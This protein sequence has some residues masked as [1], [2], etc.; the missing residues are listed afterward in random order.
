MRDNPLNGKG[1]GHELSATEIRPADFPLGSPKSRA[2]ARALLQARAHRTP[3]EQEHDK[4]DARCGEVNLREVA[5]CPNCFEADD[6]TGCLFW[7]Q[8]LTMTED[9]HWLAKGT[10]AK[11]PFP[12]KDYFRYVLGTMQRPLAYPS[13]Q[14]QSLYIPKTREMMTSWLA[15]GYIAWLCQW[16]PGIFFVLQ[17]EKEDKAVE[18]VHYTKILWDNQ[19]EF[20]KVRHPLVTDNTLERIWKNGSRV[21]GVPKGENQIRVHHPFGYLADEAAYLPE[22]ELCINAVLPVAKQIIA[23]S[24]AAPGPFADLCDLAEV[25]HG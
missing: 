9:A 19:E 10:P 24:S 6:T 13:P 22:F 15:C 3:E 21:L 7:L 11:A 2:A 16:R 5:G 25:S 20:L 18:L 8:N 4:L 23:V 1:N 14:C 12:K 17:T